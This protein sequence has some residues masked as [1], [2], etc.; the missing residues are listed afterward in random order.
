MHSSTLWRGAGM[1]WSTCDPVSREDKTRV[2]TC[3]HSPKPTVCSFDASGIPNRL[4]FTLLICWHP[5]HISDFIIMCSL[6]WRRIV[7]AVMST[8]SRSICMN[9]IGG[10]RRGREFIRLIFDWWY[11]NMLHLPYWKAH[12]ISC[13]VEDARKSPPNVIA[14]FWSVSGRRVELHPA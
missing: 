8:S 11:S 2:I 7:D 9:G 10:P 1:H 5:F 4:Q 13:I 3:Y 12:I 14:I 6:K